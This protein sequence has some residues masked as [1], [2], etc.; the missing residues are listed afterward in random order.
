MSTTSFLQWI[1]EMILQ[2]EEELRTEQLELA[3]LVGRLERLMASN[4]SRDRSGAPRLSTRTASRRMQPRV[5]PDEPHLAYGLG[6][7][8]ALS[9][10]A[11]TTG[12]AA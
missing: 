8:T 7:A 4:A 10:L 9:L 6:T 11:G 12:A 5:T 3:R 2:A 1:D